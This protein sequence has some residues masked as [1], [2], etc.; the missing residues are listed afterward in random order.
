MIEDIYDASLVEYEVMQKN[1]F[2]QLALAD[3]WRRANKR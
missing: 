1:T 2:S 3:H